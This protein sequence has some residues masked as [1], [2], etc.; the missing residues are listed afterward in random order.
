MN[1]PYAN[2]STSSRKKISFKHCEFYNNTASKFGGVIYTGLNARRMKF[3]KCVFENNYAAFGN[4][5]YAYSN[6]D[7]PEFENVTLTDVATV[8]T[9]FK[10]YGNLDENISIL[11]GE[12]IPEGIMCKLN[13]MCIFNYMLKIYISK[14]FLIITDN[15]DNNGL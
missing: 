1:C 13:K 3:K 7:L 6:D 2:V 8:P 10:R 12:K 9:Y 4:D 14:S 5:L 15:N 11:S